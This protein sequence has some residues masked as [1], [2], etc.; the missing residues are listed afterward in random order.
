MASQVRSSSVDRLVGRDQKARE[1]LAPVYGWFTEG[2]TRAPFPDLVV[3]YLGMR[4]NALT[5][6]KTSLAL[7]PKSKIPSIRNLTG[8]CCTKILSCR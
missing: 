8:S 7:V 6:V 5:G 1:L 4:V 3:I 2:S